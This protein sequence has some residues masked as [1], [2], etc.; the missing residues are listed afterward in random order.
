MGAARERAF[1]ASLKRKEDPRL[2]AGL[3]RFVGDLRLP[4]MLYGAV[5]R[6]RHAHARIRAIDGARAAA[7]AGVRRIF[8]PADLESLPRCIPQLVLHPELRSCTPPLL[9][10]ERAR[11]VGEP[12][13]FVVADDPYT[14]QDAAERVLVEYEPLPAVVDPEWALS[15]AAPCLHDAA[16][17]NLG[18]QVT[19]R[20]GD[21]EAAFAA[22]D[23]VV[24]DRFTVTRGT[25]QSL[26]TRGVLATYEA[27]SGVLRVWS[28]TQAPHQVRWVLA[29][30]LNLPEH[31]IHVIAPD[32]GGGFGPKGVIYPEEFLVPFAAM[33][34]G[35]PVRWSEDRLEHSMCAYHEHR[36]VH[37]AALALRRD[38]AILGLRDR[39]IC[40]AGA[41]TPY[42]MVVP[43]VSLSC[44]PG[45]YRVPNFD[46]SFRLAYTNKAPTAPVRGAGQPQATFVM[47]R[48]LDRAA[49]ELGLDRAE[50]RL[51][52]FVQPGDMPYKTGIAHNGVPVSYDNVDFPSCLRRVM[53]TAGY[54]ALRR[55]AEEQ[56][57]AGRAVG[58]GVA[59]YVETTGLGPFE[60]ATVRIDA[61]GRII[62]CSGAASQGQGHAT[63]LAQVCADEL[64]V[65]PEEIEV[66]VGDTAGIPF[67]VG[68]FASRTAV[69]AANAVS[70]AARRLREKL[71]EIAA[72]RLEANPGDL[73]LRGGS[74]VVRGSS[75]RA[76]D[77]AELSRDVAGAAHGYLN[78]ASPGLEA[79]EYFL[80]PAATYSSGAH[81]VMLEVDAASSA[82]RLLRYAA[83]SDCGRMI[84]PRIVDG[85]VIGGIAHGVATALFEDVRYD[86]EGQPLTCSFM[87]YLLPSA[88]ELPSVEVRHLEVPS[89]RNPRG[90][91]GVGESGVIAPG[92]AIA[93]AIEDALRPRDVRITCL[94]LPPERLHGIINGLP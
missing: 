45:C 56:R 64:G 21:A 13:A 11:Y 20:S 18:A 69:V 15:P 84:N 30:L 91:K 77:L 39:F 57:R 58:V 60:G 74:I 61:T 68:T 42:G 53:E 3:G 22:A 79:T 7:L 89:L 31:R 8:T 40:D 59:C 12:L 65:D 73:E 88:A 10:G 48:L 67:G 33:Q 49:D 14:A 46:L 6:S 51:A 5:V 52:N 50:L 28:S 38:G 62:L 78:L 1:G 43:L 54:A 36:Q 25:A 44:L 4:G 26:E 76:L 47:E 2:L 85:Q 19:R 32:V 81:L 66:Q 16:P 34:L 72:A 23:L 24:A 92:A 87:D 70:L 55:E 9:A 71:V 80:P 27:A 37:D 82:V 35:A 63:T 17:G 83:V 29:A 93:S 90:I 75:E 41:Y 86:A 94:P